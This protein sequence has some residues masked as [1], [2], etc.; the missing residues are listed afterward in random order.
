MKKDKRWK[1][2]GELTD[3][4][5]LGLDGV[6]DKAPRKT[7]RAIVM[8][9]EGLY[10]VVY[11][12]KFNLHGL[13]GGGIE[14]GETKAEALRREVL[15]ETGCH[16]DMIR[17]LGIISENRAHADYTVLSYYFIVHTHTKDGV[18]NYT[19]GEKN[20][21]TS[22]RWCTLEE[23]NHLVRDIEHKTNQRKFLQARDII[24]LDE[25]MRRLND[26]K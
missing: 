8:N 11:A 23:M 5:V 10:A 19:K 24:A 4:T 6:S 20:L 7:A 9:D 25:Y 14:A 18:P 21:G 3:K 12:K 17:P 1:V 26:E 15:E 22:L 13:P 2:I 16:C